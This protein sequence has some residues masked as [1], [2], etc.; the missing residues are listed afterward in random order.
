MKST[1]NKSGSSSASSE[2]VY[3]VLGMG[4]ID[5]TYTLN[6]SEEDVAKYK[7]DLD[8]VNS[9]EDIGFLEDAKNLWVKIFISSNNPTLSTLIYLNR[10]SDNKV[11]V[12]YLCYKLPCYD[13]KEKPFGEMFTSVNEINFLFI[14]HETALF[15]NK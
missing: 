4:N 9:L 7:I 8:K 13:E 6:L 15:P 12:E 11:F 14:N 10:A 1:K 5:L 2:P 3:R